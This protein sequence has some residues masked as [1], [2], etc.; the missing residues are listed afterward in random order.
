MELPQKIRNTIIIISLLTLIC[1]I[2]VMAGWLF[3]LSL[4]QKLVFAGI[5]MKFNTGLCFALFGAAL[6]VLQSGNK[7]YNTTLFFAFA[8]AGTLI[9]LVTFC[10]ELFSFN[11]DIDTFFVKDR[12]PISAIFPVPGRMAS[13]SSFNFTVLGIALLII[14]SPNRIYKIAAQYIFHLVTMLSA[15]ALTGFL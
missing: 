8:D 15:I 11:C 14:N 5:P 9:W 4:L 2:T 7:K 13:N 3:D 12:T 10:Q 6:L 1:G